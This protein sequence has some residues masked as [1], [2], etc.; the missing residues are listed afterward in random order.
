MAQNDRIFVKAV[1]QYCAR[2]GI[3][4]E[5]RAEGWIVAMRRGGQR[6]LAFGY[7]LGINSAVAHRIANDKSAT[8]EMLALSGIPC[9]PHRLFFNPK[10]GEHVASQASW[11]AM[12]RLIEENPAGLVVKPNEGTA[13]RSVFRISNAAGLEFAVTEISSLGM[14]VAVAPYVDIEEEVRV[15]LLDEAPLVV[16]AKRRPSVVGDGRQSLEELAMAAAPAQQRSVLPALDRS[17]L[18]AIVPAGERR[19]LDWRHNLDAGARPVVLDRGEIRRI[20]VR[21]AVDAARAIGIRFTS[22]DLVRAG[23]DWKVLEI[24]SGVMMEALG[25]TYPDLVYAAYGAALDRIFKTQPAQADDQ[26]LGIDGAR[27]PT[28][29]P[30]RR[31]VRRRSAPIIPLARA[32]GAD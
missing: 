26:G 5:L 18:D 6:H 19:L 24:N 4:V 14:A 30:Q 3:A 17:E 8:A 22:V 28:A 29:A 9:I 23:G 21:M 32:P 12:L 27:D 16:Y 20:C 31:G 10:T 7:D 13:G 25:R 1:A 15:I 2:N 11:Q